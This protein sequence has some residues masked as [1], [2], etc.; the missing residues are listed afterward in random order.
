[1]SEIIPVGVRGWGSSLAVLLNWLCAFLVT[2]TYDYLVVAIREEGVFWLYGSIAV[3]GVIFV[4][5]W[6]PETKV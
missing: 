6:V 3:G 2:E 4:L 1:M 5:L